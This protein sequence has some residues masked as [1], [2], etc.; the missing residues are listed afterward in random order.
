MVQRGYLEVI[1]GPMFSGKTEELIRQVRRAKI[2]KKHVQ[3]FKHA[4]DARYGKDKKLYSHNGMTFES[5]LVLTAEDIFTHTDEKTELVAIDEAQ[6]FGPE[7]VPVI[8]KFLEQGKRVL[9]SGL[10]MTFDRQPFIPIPEL[11][12]LADTVTKLSS[13]CSLCGEEAVYHKRIVSGKTG[14]PLKANPKLVSKLD[15]SDYQARC[16][17]CFKK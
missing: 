5:E 15:L 1:A 13:I 6:W 8:Q 14:D 17:R 3:V 11:M 7:L 10:A 2:G 4:I 16:R 9:V 12:A